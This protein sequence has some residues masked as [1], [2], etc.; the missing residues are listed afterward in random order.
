L[1]VLLFDPSW[2]SEKWWCWGVEKFP[3]LAAKQEY[4]ACLVEL[5]WYRYCE[6]ETLLGTEFPSEPA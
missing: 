2:A 3:D 5:N 4:T 1:L 6:V